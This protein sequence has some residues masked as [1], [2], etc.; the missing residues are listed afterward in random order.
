MTQNPRSVL[1]AALFAALITVFVS[2]PAS[3]QDPVFVHGNLSWEKDLVFASATQTKIRVKLTA[4]YQASSVGPVAVG[5][6]LT[7][8][9]LQMTGSGGYVSAHTPL[10][11]VTSVN[12]ADDYFIATGTVELILD[13]ANLPLFVTYT[14]CC[15]W[16]PSWTATAVRPSS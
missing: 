10:M 11:V 3:A 8:A 13:N 4:G 16:H 7:L 6:A 12:G 9:T 14:G 2:T 1:T 15:R 5:N